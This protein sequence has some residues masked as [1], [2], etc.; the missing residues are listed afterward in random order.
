MSRWLL[1]W[2]A[3]GAFLV[4]VL[5]VAGVL[6]RAIWYGVLGWMTP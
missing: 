2:C 3:F 1:D 5:V 4:G 6:T